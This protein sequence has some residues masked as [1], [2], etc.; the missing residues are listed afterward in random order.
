[1][2]KKNEPL[3]PGIATQQTARNLIRLYAR[4]KGQVQK[5]TD[6]EDT[7]MWATEA[8]ASVRH[9]SRLIAQRWNPLKSPQRDAAQQLERPT[10]GCDRLRPVKPASARLPAAIL[11]QSVLGQPHTIA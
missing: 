9:I 1:M 2:T 11:E 10:F 4:L 8:Q 5:A 6:G 7:F 3:L